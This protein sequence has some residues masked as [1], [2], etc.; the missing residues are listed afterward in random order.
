MKDIKA[1]LDAGE[2]LLGPGVFSSNPEVV[3]MIGHLGFDWV[4]LDTEQATASHSGVELEHLIRAAEAADIAPGV[5]IP[6]ITPHSVN[7]ALNL[8]ARA[9][10]VPHVE[11][12]AEAEALVRFARYPPRG[13]RGAA[14]IVRAARYG[15]TDFDEYRT[16]SDRDVEL[17]AIVES[18]RGIDNVEEI[19]AV[20]GLDAIC[21]GTF[22]LGVSMGLAQADF[23][24]DGTAGWVHPDL[25][26]AGD[27]CLAACRATGTHPAIAAW[28][29]ESG[30]RWIEKGYRYL[31]YG[32][33]VALLLGALRGLRAEAHDLAA[34]ATDT[35]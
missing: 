19:A 34:A 27:R 3:E 14:P 13:D 35:P 26:A 29:A 2:V 7:K 21:F 24:G 5:R 32:L 12:A 23:Y 15:V 8:G 33:D 28:S 1:A 22:D 10:W 6:E 9:L 18:V 30:R 25:E 11:T 4:F 16:A 17:V 31:L 20:D